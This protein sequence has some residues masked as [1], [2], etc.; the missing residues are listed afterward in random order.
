[1]VRLIT[2]RAKWIPNELFFAE[3]DHLDVLKLP[4]LYGK[5]VSVFLFYWGIKNFRIKRG[6]WFD[7]DVPIIDPK[8]KEEEARRNKFANTYWSSRQRRNF[9]M[10][11]K[12]MRK[13]L[14]CSNDGQ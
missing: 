4:K 2:N 11:K 3:A 14:F 12:L 8:I 7:A 6:N 9:W 5:R 13:K 1:M 10:L